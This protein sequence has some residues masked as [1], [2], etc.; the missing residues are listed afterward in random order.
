MVTLWSLIRS[1]HG[2]WHSIFPSA[3]SSFLWLG[4]PKGESGS[5]LA[6][7]EVYPLNMSAV[8]GSTFFEVLQ[9]KEQGESPGAQARLEKN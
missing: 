4:H 9:E 5:H 8:C 6:G 7:P 1:Y 3:S 2:L